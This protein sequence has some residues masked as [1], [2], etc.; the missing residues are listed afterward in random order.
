M[1][2]VER[3]VEV[4]ELRIAELKLK[5]GAKLALIAPEAWTPRDIARFQ[6]YARE[7]FKAHNY[8][9]ELLCFPHGVELAVITPAGGFTDVEG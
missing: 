2:E 7:V 4:L 6:E 3:A 8:D 9:F 1:S 5:P